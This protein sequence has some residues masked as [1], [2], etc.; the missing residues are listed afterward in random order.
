MGKPGETGSEEQA[1]ST[2]D[3]GQASRGARPPGHRTGGAGEAQGWAH[4]EGAVQGLP[5]GRQRVL[6]EMGVQQSESVGQRDE[7]A[8]P[9]RLWPWPW[10]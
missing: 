1:G 9:S 7:E 4:R 10:S 8:G 5:A 2:C 3:E 6:E